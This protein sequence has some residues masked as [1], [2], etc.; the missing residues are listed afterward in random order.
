MKKIFFS[1]LLPVIVFLSGFMF[2][3]GLTAG[4]QKQWTVLGP[5]DESM[6]ELDAFMRSY[7]EQYDIKAGSLAIARNGKIIYAKGFTNAEAG[8]AVTMPTSLFRIAS[9]TKVIT[10]MV[11][12]QLIENKRTGLDSLVQNILQ[13]KDP[14]KGTNPPA[15]AKPANLLANGNYFNAI[16]IRNLLDHRGGWDRD[17]NGANDPT[18]LH[19]QD[20]ANA[21]NSGKLPVSKSQLLAW[22]AMQ[23][24][25]FY[26]GADRHY[27]NFGYLVLGSVIEAK[28]R[29]SY[30]ASVKKNLLDPLKIYRPRQSFALKSQRQPGEVEYHDIPGWNGNCVTGSPGSCPSPYGVEN[31]F[32]FDSFGGWIMSAVDY[33][34][35]IASYRQGIS[36]TPKVTKDD[37]ITWNKNDGISSKGTVY[38][39]GGMLPG[40]W[41]YMAHR[42]D[43]IDLM[44]VWNT[45]NSKSSFTYK[46]IS[47]GTGNHAT[48]WHRIL[49]NI[50]TWPSYDLSPAY[51]NDKAISVQ[52][53]P[54][55]YDAVWGPS[56][57]KHIV[58]RR[59][60][61]QE[62]EALYGKYYD[63]HGLISQQTYFINGVEYH[64]GIWKP[65]KEGQFVTWGKSMADF[66]KLYDEWWKKGY[67]LIHQQAYMKNGL[68]VY[69][70][71]WNPNTGGQFVTWEKSLADFATLYDQQW[72]KGFKLISMQTCVKNGQLLYSGI[73]NPNAGGQFV[74][75]E[76]SRDDF[77]KLY[78]QQWAKG[79]RLISMQACYKNGQLLYNGIWN[80]NTN[81][82]Y[83][84]WGKTGE[85]IDAENIVQAV[86]GLQPMILC[87]Y[88]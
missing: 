51:F 81:G 71:I 50:T 18:Y 87:V 20:V 86:A 42:A 33:V 31:N 35:L 27:S 72:K 5:S 37:L 40:T 4:A 2:F 74:T 24:Q 68:L 70:G 48:I 59:K 38:D 43:G 82:Q 6:K 12:H 84:S 23:Q 62:F 56:N 58:E 39:H 46:N 76:K 7:M 34:K 26:P 10:S 66:Q 45:T 1:K 63:T 64:D 15:N 73:W 41:S 75:W 9:C 80:P 44:V 22:G 54:F 19:D 65:M 25:Q 55:E 67:R 52:P 60:T 47:Y 77:S 85:L 36:P 53:A 21:Y 29:M 17:A 14:L 11:I 83:V 8:Y 32:N 69:D 13:V 57:V 16:T 30:I 28:T 3:T 78:D 61:A 79:F 88:Q 49:D